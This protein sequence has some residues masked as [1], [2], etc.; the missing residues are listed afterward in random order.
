MVAI[1]RDFAQ[2]RD[3]RIGAGRRA[4]RAIGAYLA[5][6]KS[7]WPITQADADAFEPPTALGAPPATAATPASSEI[8]S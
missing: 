2:A 1:P 3:Q 5:G 7:T 4:A 8:P 6:G